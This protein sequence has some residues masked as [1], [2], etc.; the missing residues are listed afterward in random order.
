[1]VDDL[2]HNRDEKPEKPPLTQKA[3]EMGLQ[4]L[5]FVVFPTGFAHGLAP[6]VVPDGTPCNSRSGETSALTLHQSTGSAPLP[7]PPESS[8]PSHVDTTWT[9]GPQE[10]VGQCAAPRVGSRLKPC[11]DHPLHDSDRLTEGRRFVRFKFAHSEPYLSTV[12][13]FPPR[14]RQLLADV[15]RST[16]LGSAAGEPGQFHWRCWQGSTSGMGTRWR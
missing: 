2:P 3:L 12:N 16:P 9:T 11:E 14:D 6:G 7:E 4:P 13:N 15:G 1:M 10:R 8:G 5:T